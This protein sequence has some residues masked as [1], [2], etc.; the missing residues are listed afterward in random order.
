M[1]SSSTLDWITTK[2]FDNV[3]KLKADGS[4]WDVWKWQVTMILWHQNLLQI[5]EGTMPKPTPAAP[6]SSGKAPSGSAT[7]P[8]SNAIEIELWEKSNLEANLQIYM[9]LEYE[10]ASLMADWELVSELWST[11]H[12][13]FDSQGL[14]AMATIAHKLWHYRILPDQDMATQVQEIKNMAIKLKSLG[15]PLSEEFQTIAILIAILT[16]LP[17]EWNTIRDIILNKTRKFS[18]QATIDA[19]LEHETV[20]KHDQEN[21]LILSQSSKSKLF[22]SNPDSKGTEG[23]MCSNCKRPSH[24]VDHCWAKGGGAEGKGPKMRPL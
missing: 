6:P 8:P 4:N 10:V 16:A 9:T 21:A 13:H 22:F 14:P 17:S 11:I 1:S 18:L 23:P 3:E 24:T 7:P 15:Y 12:V 20:L 5:T 2:L 19:L